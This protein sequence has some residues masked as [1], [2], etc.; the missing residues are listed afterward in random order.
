MEA[1]GA[2]LVEFDLAVLL[3]GLAHHLRRELGLHVFSKRNL[4]VFEFDDVVFCL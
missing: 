3:E 4:I 1:G 2:K